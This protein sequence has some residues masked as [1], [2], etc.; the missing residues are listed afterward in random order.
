[1]VVAMNPLMRDDDTKP[2]DQDAAGQ[3]FGDHDID[4]R[5]SAW[6]FVFF[7]IGFLIIVGYAMTRDVPGHDRVFVRE[8]VR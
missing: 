8:R 1:M 5:V 6:W 4:E 3:R 2:D 7:M